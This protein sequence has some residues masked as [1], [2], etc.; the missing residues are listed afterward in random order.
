MSTKTRN[1]LPIHR[2]VDHHF[3]LDY[4]RRRTLAAFCQ[5]GARGRDLVRKR[6]WI[7]EATFQEGLAIAQLCPGALSVQMAM[8]L[9]YIR[10]GAARAQ[11]PLWPYVTLARS[12]LATSGLG[13]WATAPERTT[14]CPLRMRLASSSHGKHRPEW[15][16]ASFS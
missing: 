5:T 7:G 12:S 1:R 4:R 11:H 10:A 14:S 15:P 8:Y 2:S 9:G 3:P 6:A 16:L 13:R